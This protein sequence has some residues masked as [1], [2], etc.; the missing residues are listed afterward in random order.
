MRC[1]LF[2]SILFCVYET[3]QAQTIYDTREEIP[4]EYKWKLDDIYTD[5]DSWEKDLSRMN[6]LMTELVSYKGKLKESS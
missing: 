5:W 6:E 2:I 4:A 1:L 3:N